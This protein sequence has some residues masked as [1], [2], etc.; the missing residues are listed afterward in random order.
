MKPYEIIKDRVK[1]L[2]QQYKYLS[3]FIR[4]CHESSDI[5]I[6]AEIE[7]KQFSREI[8]ALKWVLDEALPF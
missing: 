8:D 6:K 4:S 7:L 1:E 2:E 5:K 3:E